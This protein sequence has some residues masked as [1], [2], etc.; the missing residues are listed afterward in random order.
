MPFLVTKRSAD[1]LDFG[2]RSVWRHQMRIPLSDPSRTVVDVLDD[3]SL[4]GGIRHVASVVTEYLSSEHRDDDLLV[5]YGDRVGH[6]SIFKRLGWMLELRGI[7]GPLF[8]ACLARRSAGI[9]KLDP[10]VDTP[11]RIVRRWGLR[12]NVALD[13]REDDW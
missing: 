6:R 8:D 1:K 13:E 7:D 11:G 4:G 12:V 10:T 3:P 5:E 2:L 9:V